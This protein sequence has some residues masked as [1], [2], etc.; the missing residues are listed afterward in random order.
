[1]S[2]SSTRCSGPACGS[3]ELREK[4]ARCRSLVTF[5]WP[6]VQTDPVANA[7]FWVCS[8]LAKALA[9]QTNG[10]VMPREGAFVA[11]GGEVIE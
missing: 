7:S 10:V 3:R 6:D 9:S 4:L 1:M 2:R 5:R 8:A 11:R